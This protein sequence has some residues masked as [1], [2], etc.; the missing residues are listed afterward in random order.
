MSKIVAMA[1]PVLQ[2]A[3][4]RCY[5]YERRATHSDMLHSNELS[6]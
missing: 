1:K 6:S 4:A 3:A 5:S 2:A